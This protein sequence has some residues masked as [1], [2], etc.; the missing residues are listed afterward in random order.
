MYLNNLL[1]VATLALG[2][3]ARVNITQA[4]NSLGATSLLKLLGSYP[5]V[6]TQLDA[7]KG[8]TLLAPSNDA[9]AQLTKSGALNSATQDEITAILSYHVIGESVSYTSFNETPVF[10]PTTLTNSSYTNVTGGQVV[11]GAL[12]GQDVVFTSGLK[13]ASTVVIPPKTAKVRFTH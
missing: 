4:I 12:V 5:D 1:T 11:E 6:V 10:L 7:A 3:N 13:L 2:A 9:I 8:I